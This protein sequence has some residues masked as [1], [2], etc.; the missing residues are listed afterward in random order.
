MDLAKNQTDNVEQSFQEALRLIYLLANTFGEIPSE[1]LKVASF[2]KNRSVS[3]E[4]TPKRWM[5]FIVNDMKSSM[6]P[7]YFVNESS[8]MTHS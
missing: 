5:F 4:E 6:K 3:V 8:A 2:N 1:S 7:E